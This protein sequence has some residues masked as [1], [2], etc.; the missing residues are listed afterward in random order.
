LRLRAI[1]LA[2]TLE[3]R[4]K[5]TQTLP[6][7]AEVYVHL[8]DREGQL[9][10]WQ[11]QRENDL[12]ILELETD[13][14]QTY[15]AVSGHREGLADIL[16]AL[17]RTEESAIQLKES[18]EMIEKAVALQQAAPPSI[19]GDLALVWYLMQKAG[20]LH[21]WKRLDEALAVYQAAADLAEKTYHADNTKIFAYNHTSRTHRYM[22]DIYAEKGNWEKYLECSEFS[23]NWIKQHRDNRN[24]WGGGVQPNTSYYMVRV[25]I[26]LNKLGRR[27][28]SIAAVEDGLKQYREGLKSDVNHG[29]KLYY[30]FELLEPG[31]EFYL[32]TNQDD[33]AVELWEEYIHLLEPFVERNPDDTT[34]R[35]LLAHA[36]ERKGDVLAR[37]VNARETFD[38]TDRTRLRAAVSSYQ[39]SIQRRWK[40]IELDP[41]NQ[42]HRE[43]EKIV[44]R[45]VEQLNAKLN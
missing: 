8:A 21:R 7:M 10:V 43:S 5:L 29:E 1:A 26:G 14:P 3:N 45:K 23:V 42:A 18:F 4:K 31:T 30:A 6:N 28:A 19:D 15:F 16:R 37:Y 12:R 40:I 35:G 34:S 11:E 32:D 25:G 41:A 33:K 36:I 2:P 39:E 38:Q 13:N 24:V 9:L 44:E 17:G 27:A 22:A 20:L